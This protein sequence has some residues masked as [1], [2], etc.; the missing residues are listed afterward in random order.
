M[1][2]TASVAV[3][4]VFNERGYW[5]KGYTYTYD[6]NLVTGTRVV[7]PAGEWHSV[8]RVISCTDDLTVLNPNITYKRIEAVLN[9]A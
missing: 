2:K 7:V 1:S 9:D 5:S 3:S 4:V 8:G 6:R